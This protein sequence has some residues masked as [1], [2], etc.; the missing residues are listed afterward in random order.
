MWRRRVGAGSASVG[1]LYPVGNTG[2]QVC[3]CHRTGAGGGRYR[4]SMMMTVPGYNEEAIAIQQ[5]GAANEANS[6][7]QGR[8]R[9]PLTSGLSPLKAR[10][11]PDEPATLRCTASG[12]VVG[13]PPCIRQRPGPPRRF[14]WAEFKNDG[15]GNHP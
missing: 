6:T 1:R 11:L 7:A 2:K 3:P 13:L 5:C 8:A 10:P 12:A 9:W 15:R 14:G 4:T